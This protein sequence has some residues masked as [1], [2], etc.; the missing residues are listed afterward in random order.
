MHHSHLLCSSLCLVMQSSLSFCSHLS[1]SSSL[2]S[3]WDPPFPRRRRYLR[4]RRVVLPLPCCYDRHRCHSTRSS[5]R[6]VPVQSVPRTRRRLNLLLHHRRRPSRFSSFYCRKRSSLDTSPYLHRRTLRPRQSLR[7][8]NPRVNLRT[9]LHR[10]FCPSR[11]R[12]RRTTH[13]RTTH[14]S[15]SF[16]CRRRLFPSPLFSSP[17]VVRSTSSS[18]RGLRLGF[19]AQTA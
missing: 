2:S 7:Q 5:P 14:L 1:S 8:K 3:S 15:S 11:R 16:E 10:L 6:S 17:V 4:A 13:R 9:R 18:S 19:S 12:H